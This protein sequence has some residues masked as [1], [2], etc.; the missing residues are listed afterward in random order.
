[1]FN[2][3]QFRRQPPSL[4]DYLPWALLLTPYVVLCK[5]GSLM[6]T[7]RFRGIDTHCALPSTLRAYRAQLNNA[8]RRFGSGWC[9]HFE[10][11]RSL[12]EST[13]AHQFTMPLS[14]MLE[15]ER[16]ARRAAEPRYESIHYLT[17]TWLVPPD[18]T[19]TALDLLITQPDDEPAAERRA[20]DHLEDFERSVAQAINVLRGA[21]PSVERLGDEELLSYLHDCVSDRSLR[22]CRPEIPCYLDNV[23]TDAPLSGGVRP[24]LGTRYLQTVA[25]RSYSPATIPCLLDALNDLPLAYRWCVRY[26]PLNRDAAIAEFS[27]IRR[28]WFA[29]RKSLWTLVREFITQTESAQI[30]VEADQKAD[31]VNHALLGISSD[32]CSFGYATLT[33]TTWGATEQAALQNAQAIQQVVDNVGMVAR[34]EDFN[35]VQAWLGSLPGHAYANVRKPLLSSLNLCD[36]IPASTVYSG[37][38]RDAHLDGPPLLDVHTEGATPLRIALHQ[39]D[40]GHCTILGPTG[41]GK[42]TLL[43]CI[44]EQ[45]QRYPETQIFVFDKGGSARAMT[46]AMGGEWY[47]LSPE[48]T[49][50]SFQ[51]LRGVD[52]EGERSWVHDWLVDIA[53]REGETV[54]PAAK[55]EL[56]AALTNLGTMPPAQRTLTIFLQ[57]L[58]HQ[59]LR[60]ALRPYSLEGP[61][62]KLLDAE[63]DQLTA[64]CW[65]TFEVEQLMQQP[66][67]L[68]AVLPYLFHRLEQRFG[69]LAETADGTLR[70]V[71]TLLILDEAWVMLDDTEFARQIRMWLKTLRKKNVAV[72][73]ATQSLADVSASSI[74]HAIIESCPTRILLPNAAAGEG[75]SRQL[76]ESFGLNERQIE[77]IRT[78]TPKQDYYYVTPVGQRMF[79]LNLGPL[80]LALCGTG[81]VTQQAGIAELWDQHGREGFAAAYLEARGLPE[82]AAVLRQRQ[83]EEDHA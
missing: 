11:A 39:G 43:R 5:D 26:L 18:S 50:L 57:L 69:R 53:R 7:V 13:H 76:Y 54:D 29:R 60:E 79:Q 38:L 48:A 61:Y 20:R 77:R 1:M 70:A 33:I 16:E 49:E 17:L 2:I 62:G 28:H 24:R 64:S 83:Q 71:L 25:V 8:L 34:I 52:D 30:N 80:A 45:A 36:L 47:D 63:D 12:A 58:Q 51:P 78:A 37:P 46:L 65:Q 31:D 81:S 73:F 35:A 42:S 23:L 72:I 22:I 21:M 66:A 74:A 41:M 56:W 9:L 68:R 19:K 4:S 82:A 15:A 14:H 44:E 32:D 6:T 10:S 27:R 40:V 75:T 67:L 3:G 55:R 59:R